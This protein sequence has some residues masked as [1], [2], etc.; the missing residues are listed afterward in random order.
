[1]QD[2]NRVTLTANLTKDPELFT[3][4]SGFAICTLRVA[5]NTSRK[6][7]EGNWSDKPNYFDVK[8]MGKQGE[9]AAKY[10]AKGR[11][12]AVDGQLEWREFQTAD[13]AKRQSVEIIVSL[14]GSVKFLG[15]NPNNQASAV[16]EETTS[17]SASDLDDDMPF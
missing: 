1:M 9:N 8:V 17:S 11:P 2:I 5:S 13:G 3:T 15:S 6:D 12:I 10:L 7:A 14:N 16:T 4:E